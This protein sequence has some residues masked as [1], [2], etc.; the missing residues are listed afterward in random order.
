MKTISIN[1][2]FIAAIAILFSTF[3]FTACQKENS[4]TDSSTVTEEEA[5]NLS[6]ESSQA[7]ASFDDADDISFTAAEEE[8]NAGGFGVEGLAANNLQGRP[9]LPTFFELRQRI[10]DCATITV[11]PNDSTYPKTVVIDFGDSCRGRDGKVRSGKI[12]LHFTGPIR[13]PGSVVTLTFVNYYVNRVHIEG[14]KV[15]SNL[16]V[17]PV[18]KWKIAAINCKVTFPS[19]RGYTYEGIK[20]VKQIAGMLTNICRDDVYEITGNSQTVFN[21]GKTVLINTVDPLIKKVACHWISDGTLKIKINDRVLKLDF[22]FPNNGDCDNK[23]LLTWNNGN[24][25]RVIILP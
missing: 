5:A 12:V 1:R 15:F 24:S 10:G 7:E 25:Q 23:A 22:G 19:G 8:G 16:S 14:T 11:T 21:N 6:D 13:R 20:N 18:H 2:I 9:F 17:P 4:L 3:I